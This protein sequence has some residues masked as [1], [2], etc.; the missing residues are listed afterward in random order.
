MTVPTEK[1]MGSIVTSH[2]Y[3]GNHGKPCVHHGTPWPMTV[4]IEKPMVS[5]DTPHQYHVNHGKPSVWNLGTHVCTMGKFLATINSHGAIGHT[6]G[7]CCRP[8]N[9]RWIPRAAV[10]NARILDC[11]N[12]IWKV[13]RLNVFCYFLIFCL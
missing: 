10:Y 4:P 9:M 7:V 5:V 12:F 8:M 11:H 2:W 13:R 6:N 1:T 3:H